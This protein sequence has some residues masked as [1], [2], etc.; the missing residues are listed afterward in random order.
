M[1]LFSRLTFR[2]DL[3]FQHGSASV[4]AVLP[5]FTGKNYSELSIGDGGTASLKFV[6]MTFSDVSAE[7][8]VKARQ[9]LEEYCQL[10]A[11]AI[12]WL[13]DKLREPAT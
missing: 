9:H 1:V 13:A 5:E 12:V 7:E 4:K 2:D 10:D 8:R 3:L 6:R 11:L